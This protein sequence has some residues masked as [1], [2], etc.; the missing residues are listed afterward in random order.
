MKTMAR[1]AVRQ[2]SLSSLLRD[3]RIRAGLTQQHLADLSALSVRAIRDLESGRVHRPRL[4]TVR[5]LADGL[6]LEGR[7]RAIFVSM[8]TEGGSQGA[9][10]SAG[11]AKAASARLT[12]GVTLSILREDCPDDAAP[13]D[14][15]THH[16]SVIQL[17]DGDQPDHLF[18]E[19]RMWRVGSSDHATMP[20]RALPIEAG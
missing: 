5:L 17:N 8:A 2:E 11:A 3:L 6:A 7:T 4:E 18:L 20:P 10:I 19:I 12:D 9:R 15:A 14:G 13:P 16:V 1:T